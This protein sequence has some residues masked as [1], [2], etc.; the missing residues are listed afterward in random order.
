MPLDLPP[1]IHPRAF[2]LLAVEFEAERFNEVQLRPRRRAEARHVACVRRNFRFNQD[3]VH[4]GNTKNQGPNS[5]QRQDACWPRPSIDWRAC[6]RISLDRKS[7]RLNS[8][9]RCISYAVFC[10]KKKKKTNKE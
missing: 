6:S 8:S 2:E 7:T 1:V 4:K 5:K 10:L 9:H 3:D